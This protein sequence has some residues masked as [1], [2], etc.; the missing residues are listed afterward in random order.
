[1]LFLLYVNL[2][3]ELV[4]SSQV[5]SFAADTNIVKTIITKED[6]S[7]LQADIRNIVSSF[8]LLAWPLMNPN[9]KCN[10]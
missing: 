4:T 7:L 9:V 1:M 6:S 10:G 5:A 2:S 3:P 8:S